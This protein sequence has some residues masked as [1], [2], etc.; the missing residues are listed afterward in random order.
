M[1]KRKVKNRWFFIVFAMLGFSMCLLGE[2]MLTEN[3]KTDVV[4]KNPFEFLEKSSLPELA[5]IKI[6]KIFL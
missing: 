4:I 2:S 6:Y 5:Q 1:K 3:I